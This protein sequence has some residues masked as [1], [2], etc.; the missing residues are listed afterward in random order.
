VKS[1]GVNDR[2]ISCLMVT[3]ASRWQD[4]PPPGAL[5]FLA[6]TYACR[7]LVL[8]SK[9]PCEAMR[10]FCLRVNEEAWP[11]QAAAFFAIEEE[12]ALLGRLRQIAVDNAAGE[13]VA[14]WDDDDDSAPERLAV[15][16]EALD[17]VEVSDACTLLRVIVEDVARARRFIGPRL[18]WPQTMLARRISLPT[19]SPEKTMGEDSEVISKMRTLVVLDRPELYTYRVHGAN[20][21]AEADWAAEAWAMRTGD[22]P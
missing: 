3:Q 6:Q 7:E 15:Q 10:Q 16:L 2:L 18:A 8:V 11:D 13:Y 12:P 1:L 21:A 9:Q 20:V 5:A 19:Y 4:G 14:T 22:A 17:G